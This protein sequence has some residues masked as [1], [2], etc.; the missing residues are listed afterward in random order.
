MKL[1]A[2]GDGAELKLLHRRGHAAKLSAHGEDAK[3]CLATS[4]QIKRH[5]RRRLKK[6]GAV[7]ECAE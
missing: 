5:T 3:F 4:S 1:G 6:L 7:G 2:V